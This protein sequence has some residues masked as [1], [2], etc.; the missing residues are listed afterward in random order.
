MGTLTAVGYF[1][2]EI[3]WPFRIGYSFVALLLLVQPPMFSAAIWLN[4][5]GFV[6]AIGV[7]AWEWTRGPELKTA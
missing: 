6:M 2:R 3:S 7:I 4:V 5:I 1:Q